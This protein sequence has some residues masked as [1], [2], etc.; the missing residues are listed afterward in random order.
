M[1]FENSNF[2]PE[3]TQDSEYRF[4]LDTKEGVGEFYEFLVNEQQ[5]IGVLDPTLDIKDLALSDPVALSLKRL[6]LEFTDLLRLSKDGLESSEE[7]LPEDLVDNIIAQYHLY[8]TTADTFS[9]LYAAESNETPVEVDVSVGETQAP[10]EETVT[11]ESEPTIDT[12]SLES[13]AA[14]SLIN[15]IEADYA[16]IK[17]TY[18][19]V[20]GQ[21][22]FDTWSAEVQEIFDTLENYRKEALK[23]VLSTNEAVKDSYMST[24]DLET[25]LQAYS[26]IVENIRDKVDVFVSSTDAGLIFSGP[27]DSE[28]EVSKQAESSE[29]VTVP[30]SV[31]ALNIHIGEKE[32]DVVTVDYSLAEAKVAELQQLLKSHPALTNDERSTLQW[33]VENLSEKIKTEADSQVLQQALEIADSLV[34][35]QV[36]NPETVAIIEKAK[37]LLNRASDFVFSENDEQQTAQA[38]AQML[39]DLVEEQQ[40]GNV[41]PETKISQAYQNLENFMIENESKWLKVCGMSLPQAGPEAVFGARSFRDGLEL[42]RRSHPDVKDSPEKQAV[43]DKIIQLLFVVPQSGLTVENVER[44][45]AL[46]KELNV[47]KN[48]IEVLQSGPT[49]VVDFE[50]KTD[51]SSEVVPKDV[52]MHSHWDIRN[53]P[54]DSDIE[55]HYRKENLN[56]WRN[57]T[58]KL[59][60]IEADSK[61]DGDIKI[62]VARKAEEKINIPDTSVAAVSELIGTHGGEQVVGE[63]E[64]RDVIN[65]LV[66]LKSQRNSIKAESLRQNSLTA[67]YLSSNP[68]YLSFFGPET[69]T[70]TQFEKELQSTIKNI[71]AEKISPFENFFDQPFSSAFAFIKDMSLVELNTLVTAPPAERKEI[72]EDSNIKYEAFLG[73][74]DV[75]ESQMLQV[76]D[77]KPD[78]KFGELFTKWMMEIEI[79]R[80]ENN[81]AAA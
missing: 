67:E 47:A 63:V 49:K 29:E 11:V 78:M 32:S 26:R 44:I 53:R 2:T 70:Q 45:T 36:E 21:F 56:Y 12:V 15:T 35:S 28:E 27:E 41:V 8:T 74:I 17:H 50:P 38:M 14:Q 30:N 59:L 46:A 72:L 54:S 16:D 77:G 60:G 73:W 3:N 48:T 81:S 64:Q 69:L 79:S 19:T 22:P 6:R 43:V 25:R 61:D 57:K 34:I 65:D 80:H 33:S 66:P 13:E 71:D 37:L 55:A 9:S 52:E 1:S 62:T 24:S 58:S 76:V 23:I 20:K 4:T 68:E 31:S 7:D 40:L 5:Q 18:D 39:S 51:E 42:A 75:C 10:S